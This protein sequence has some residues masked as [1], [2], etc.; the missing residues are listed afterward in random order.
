[1]SEKTIFQK[2]IDREIP[3]AII[4]ARRDPAATSSARLMIRRGQPMTIAAAAPRTG[5]M[6]GA[7]SIAPM[8]T[9]VESPRMPNTAIAVDNIMRDTKRV[10]N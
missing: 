7:T 1:M 9:A 10:K 4:T 2:I 3:A 8:T 6:S 5:N